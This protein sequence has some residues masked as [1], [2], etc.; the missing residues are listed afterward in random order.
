ML[1]IGAPVMATDGEIGTLQ[2]VILNPNTRTVSDIVV[3]S[4]R[5]FKRARV[6]SARYIDH[7][8]QDGAIH[9]SVDSEFV[10]NCRVFAHKEFTTPEWASETGYNAEHVLIWHDPYAGPTLKQLPRPVVRV[11]IDRGTDEMTPLVGRGSAVYTKTGERVGTVDH[12]AVDPATLQPLYVVVR[13]PGI[14]RRRV[15]V[16]ADQ[17]QAWQHQSITLALEKKDLHAL[18]PY[19]PRTPDIKLGEA[20]REAI[21]ALGIP[22]DA[23]SV[24]VDKGHV[25]L[26]GHTHSAE[27]RRRIE[28]AVRQVE[29]VLSVTNEMTTDRQLEVQV[30]S[31]LLADPVAGLYP[32]DVVV[33]NRVATVI[34][35]VPH[36]TIQ[37]L[38]LTIV[39]QTPGITAVIDQITVDPNAFQEEP[40]P[41]IVM[42]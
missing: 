10:R 15:V 7:V 37:H 6:I 32:V 5:L 20:V 42:R 25:L 8:D 35:T 12:I 26:R 3:R 2:Y 19:T 13:L 4:G 9:L 36:E 17:V 33:Q 40:L 29:G 31:R 41:V 34:G 39:R 18:P 23:L 24:F 1:R 22:V 30:Q 16:P 11:H 28:A 14:R 27:D 21:E 38:I